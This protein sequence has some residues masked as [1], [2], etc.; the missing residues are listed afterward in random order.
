MRRNA[1]RPRGLDEWL[2]EQN[3]QADDPDGQ[4]LG[5]RLQQLI[6][7][8]R[9]QFQWFALVCSAKRQ[10]ELLDHNDDA[11]CSEH[12]VYGRG[13]KK[14]AQLSDAQHAEQDLDD[15]RRHPHRERHAVGLQIGDRIHSPGVTKGRH[16]RHHNQ[17]QA[18]GRAFNGELRIAQQRRHKR[19]DNSRQDTGHR[20]ITGG[21]GDSQAK[22]Q[23][24][25]EDQ[26]ARHQIV[27]KIFHEAGTITA[28]RFA[29]HYIR[30]ITHLPKFQAYRGGKRQMTVS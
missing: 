9:Q 14:V 26:K 13:R 5:I 2:K 29:R 22:G 10:G 1:F 19:A 6:R 17:N 23:R 16:S 25:Q 30:T 8:L 21:L 12:P 15:S 18:R 27:T 4:N 3:Q 20:W 11:D 28:R 24:N 7:N